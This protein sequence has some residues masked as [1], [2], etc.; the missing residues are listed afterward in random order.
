MDKIGENEDQEEI[1]EGTQ[2]NV[3]D[4]VDK[5][6]ENEV[7]KI[8]ENEDQEKIGEGTQQNAEDKVDKVD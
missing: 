8:G 2:Q 5:I 4:K 6:G 3:E 7:D 1:G